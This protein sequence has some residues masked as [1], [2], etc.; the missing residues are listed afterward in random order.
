MSCY[1]KYS[2]E[3]Y[4][5]LIRNLLGSWKLEDRCSHYQCFSQGGFCSDLDQLRLWLIYFVLVFAAFYCNLNNKA[6]LTKF[7][8]YKTFT[9]YSNFLITSTSGL[10]IKIIGLLSID[11]VW[12]VFPSFDFWCATSRARKGFETP[13]QKV[14]GPCGSNFMLK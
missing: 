2:R 9:F 1:W 7:Y 11:L 14:D 4:F 6:V 13:N 10:A 12:C 5:D 3:T 8:S